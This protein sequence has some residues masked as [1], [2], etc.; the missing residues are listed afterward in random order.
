MHFVFVEIIE[1]LSSVQAIVTLVESM[2][3]RTV[4]RS[5]KIELIR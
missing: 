5:K 3:V 4:R 1:V 2:P